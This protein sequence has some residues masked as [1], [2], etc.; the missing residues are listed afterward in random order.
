MPSY[1]QS[2]RSRS[3]GGRHSSADDPESHELELPGLVPPAFALVWAGI[4]GRWT[5]GEVASGTVADGIVAALAGGLLGI[6]G[7][8]VWVS[9]V[10]GGHDT[11][12]DLRYLESFALE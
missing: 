3:D 2:S 8:A 6:G 7:V 11:R 5:A 10:E 9:V 1:Q 12:E 4:D